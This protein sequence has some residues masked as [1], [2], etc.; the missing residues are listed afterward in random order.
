[1]RTGEQR[2]TA[3]RV[4][5]ATRAT[6]TTT[7]A[8]VRAVVVETAAS[9]GQG[10]D[11]NNYKT[12][13]VVATPSAT[14]M[15]TTTKPTSKGTKTRAEK[16]DRKET[17]AGPGNSTTLSFRLSFFSLCKNGGVE[18]AGREVGDSVTW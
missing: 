14:T 8:I 4:T 9:P 12:M 10:K 16:Q 1:M 2:A 5:R 6:R 7:V 17:R 15:T 13:T 18:E 11:V 3:E